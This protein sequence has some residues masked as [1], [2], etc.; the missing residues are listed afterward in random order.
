VLDVGQGDA[1]LV[2]SPTGTQILFDA[3]PPKKILGQ[4]T[5]VMPP[6]DRHIDAIVITNPDADHIGGFSDVLKMYKVGQVF[7]PGTFNDSRTYQNLE[8]TIKNK[9]IPDILLKKGMRLDIG[10]GAVIDVLFPDRDVSM[11]DS[12]DGSVVAK[13]TYGNIS[14]M[15]T[16]DATAETEKIILEEF[17]S[18]DIHSTVLK[19]GH[20]GSRTSSSPSFVRAVNPTFA[21]ISDGKDN[22]YGH[23]HIQTLDTLTQFGAKIF[24]TDTRGTILMKSDG[25]KLNFSFAK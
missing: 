3:G 6:L 14:I 7:E 8:D 1:I 25:Q 15:L 13:L 10:G 11:W 4:L 18:V 12:N 5:R 20:H 24:R 21:V 2:E 16:G 22:T 17:S 19:V 23:P 9:K